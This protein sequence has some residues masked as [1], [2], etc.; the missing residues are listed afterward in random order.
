M[1]GVVVF[2]IPPPHSLFCPLLLKGENNE[3]CNAWILIRL[4]QFEAH[5]EYGE[6]GRGVQCCFTSMETTRPVRD[7]E[8]R[9]AALTFTQLLSS[10]LKIQCCF[11]STE[12]ISSIR[13]GEPRTV[14]LTFT[15]LLSSGEGEER[16]SII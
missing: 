16:Q 1:V 11:M 10:D 9:T 7:G 14:T 13:D 4:K 6:G 8:P 15:L 3:A 5:A 12:T 2:I